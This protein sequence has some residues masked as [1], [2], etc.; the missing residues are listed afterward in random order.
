M[1]S[2]REAVSFRLCSLLGLIAAYGCSSPPIAVPPPPK[3]TVQHPEVRELVDYDEYNGWMDAKAT[4][5]VRA[6]VRG[7]IKKVHFQDGDFVQKDQLLFELDPRPFQVSIDETLAQ[8]AALDAQ[9]VAAEKEAARNRELVKKGAVTQQELENS[10]ADAASYVARIAATLQ[11]AEKYKLDLEF[12]KIT[13][14]IAGRISRALLTE[15]NLVN[16]GGSD[17]VLTTIVAVDPIQVYFDIDERALQRYQA[18]R[19]KPLAGTKQSTVKEQKIPFSFGRETDAGY[20]Y[21]GLLDFAENRVD[22]TTGTI[23]VRGECPN[24][25]SVFIPGSRVRIRVPVSQPYQAV[26]VPDTAVLTDQDKKYLLVV[27]Q[28]KN[29]I[30]RDVHLGRLLDDGLRVVLGNGVKADEWVIVLG[31]QRARINYP[32]EPVDAKA[33][34]VAKAGP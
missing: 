19:P 2:R 9:K 20:P 30:R 34:A 16:A 22:S 21:A 29:V 32:V 25:D 28:K 1:Q 7:H 4:V 14:P 17:P 18:S 31:L 3:V 33:Q 13:A 5:E 26:L 23:Q 8:A 15:G 12:S 6:R 11:Q 24:P 27:D 10:E